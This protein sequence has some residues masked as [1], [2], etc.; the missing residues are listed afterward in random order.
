MRVKNPF[1]VTCV[2]NTSASAGTEAAQVRGMQ[3]CHGHAMREG[4]PVAQWP[5]RFLFLT[6][7]SL[8]DQL[9]RLHLVLV[10][11][12]EAQHTAGQRRYGTQHLC[13]Q[14]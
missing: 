5:L 6:R 13:D 9:K 10:G 11:V 1:D 14:G 8:V 3:P 12:G 7:L 4:A 2:S